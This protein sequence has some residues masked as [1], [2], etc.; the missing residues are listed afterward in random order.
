MRHS[1]VDLEVVC[2]KAKQ[3]GSPCE[4]RLSDDAGRYTIFVRNLFS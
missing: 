2:A 3:A 4:I 1:D